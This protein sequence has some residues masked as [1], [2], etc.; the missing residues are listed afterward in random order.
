MREKSALVK[1]CSPTLEWPDSLE[2]VTLLGV[3]IDH[4]LL[5]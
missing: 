1:G 4:V 5:F 2:L 3:G